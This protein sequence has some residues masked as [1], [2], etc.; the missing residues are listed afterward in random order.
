MKTKAKARLAPR[1][2]APKAAAAA[3]SKPKPAVKPSPKAV[4]TTRRAP[5]PAAP[6]KTPRPGPLIVVPTASPTPPPP[7]PRVPAPS[8]PSM[9]PERQQELYAEA[10]KLFA[11]QKFDRAEG[12]FQKVVT[13]PD[14][15]LADRAQVH[16][17]ICA[18]R[19]SQPRL[20]LRTAED[21]YNYAI[22]MLNQ[23]RLEEAA[24]HLD[25]ALRLEPKAEHFHYAMAATQ[26]LQGNPEA[27]FQ[28]LKSAIELEPRNRVR[29]RSDADFAGV[30][31]YPP[32]ASLLHLERRP[33]G[34]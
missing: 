21:H 18:S 22:T 16:A 7:P 8:A 13:G 28:R 3:R 24:R 15:A 29:A 23:R 34:E 4:K 1:A 17:K 14:R 27:A 20:E 30:L 11:A 32:L 2:K 25:A 12:L 33:A 5:K 9:S 26:A 6:A 10:M 31:D 19:L